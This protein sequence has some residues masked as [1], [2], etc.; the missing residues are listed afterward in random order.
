MSYMC[1][2]GNCWK[3]TP[4]GAAGLRNQ[5]LSEL[6]I[7]KIQLFKCFLNLINFVEM[8]FMV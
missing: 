7:F 4:P 5:K 2:S 1:Q 8:L 3:R 6:L